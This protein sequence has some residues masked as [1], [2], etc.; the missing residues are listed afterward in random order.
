MPQL[1]LLFF[2]GIILLFDSTM[3]S[4][5]IGADRGK[6][7]GNLL[8]INHLS[9][10]IEEECNVVV[11][12]S[13]ATN[14]DTNILTGVKTVK[15]SKTWDDAAPTDINPPK[16]SLKRHA[17][18]AKSGSPKHQLILSHSKRKKSPKMSPSLL[19]ERTPKQ[20][21]PPKHKEPRKQKGPK[22]LKIKAGQPSFPVILM[23]I[24]FLSDE[25]NFIIIN[26]DRILKFGLPNHFEDSV[27]T[28]DQLL[29]VMEIW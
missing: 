17:K 23:A 18:K 24:T 4:S 12:V 5:S 1:T 15:T 11:N 9:S 13:P 26:P 27:P 8:A 2:S 29:Q 3:Q 28:Y 16:L 19:T 10:M 22:V 6:V 25:Q 14:P 21:L 20:K 7:M